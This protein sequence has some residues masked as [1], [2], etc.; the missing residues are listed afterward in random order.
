MAGDSRQVRPLRLA[1]KIAVGYSCDDGATWH[2]APISGEW[3]APWPPW[4]D[5]DI[6]GRSRTS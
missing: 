1:A 2:T 5:C 4:E 3:C 6:F